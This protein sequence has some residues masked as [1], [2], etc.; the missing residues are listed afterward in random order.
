MKVDIHPQYH[1]KMQVSCACGNI[2]ETGSTL[3][4]LK[5]ELCNNCHPFY[6][7]KQKFVDTARRIEKFEEK[8][9]KILGDKIIGKK[10]KRAI[11]DAKKAE[12]AAEL[13]V[14]EVLVAKKN[15]I[16]KAVISQKAAK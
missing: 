3:F 16:K 6:T 5:T 9:T 7:G 14:Q 8:K 11:K 2:F 13:A 1:E 15:V 12:K 10:E 4:E